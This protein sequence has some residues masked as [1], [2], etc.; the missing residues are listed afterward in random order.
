M[1]E[2]TADSATITPGAP[3]SRL[4]GL[5]DRDPR[6]RGGQAAAAPAALGRDDAAQRLDVGAAIKRLAADPAAI[7]L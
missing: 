6:R 4:L 7:A 1:I 5:R 2:L 3:S